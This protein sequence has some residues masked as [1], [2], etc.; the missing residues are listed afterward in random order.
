MGV[1]ES[2]SGV[3]YARQRFPQCQFTN[4][5]I[6]ELPSQLLNNQF[7]LFLL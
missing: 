5:S 3:E 1:E 6:Y 7:D 2:E 4:G